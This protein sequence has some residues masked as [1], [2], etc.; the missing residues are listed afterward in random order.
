MRILMSERTPTDLA[1]CAALT[2]YL[3][4]EIDCV[5]R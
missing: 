4:I 1:E 3:R 5:I 2:A